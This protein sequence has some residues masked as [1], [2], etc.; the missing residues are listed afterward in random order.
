[1]AI[2]GIGVDVVDMPRIR[3]IVEENPKFIQRILTDKEYEQFLSRG[4]KRQVEYFAGRF[5]CKEA[6]SK[7][8]GTG[9][10][11][12]DF[13]AIEVLNEDNGRP[14]VT[15]SPFEGEV[16]VTISHSDTVAIAYMVLENK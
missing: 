1:M 2:Y 6:F 4:L 7:A 3:Q 14:I 12:I 8:W 9:I 16:H 13:K 10:G 5:A 15:S 11:P